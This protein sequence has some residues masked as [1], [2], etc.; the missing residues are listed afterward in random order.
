MLLTVL[1][2]LNALLTVN[3]GYHIMKVSQAVH[4]LEQH[5]QTILGTTETGVCVLD[6][7][8]KLLPNGEIV[9]WDYTVWLPA[10]KQAL[11]IHLNY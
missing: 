8:S 10:N 1:H 2:K 7:G 4:I 5:G 6:E 9:P 11:L 3:G